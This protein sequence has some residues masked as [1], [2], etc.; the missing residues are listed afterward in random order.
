MKENKKY[1]KNAFERWLQNIKR[2]NRSW[3]VPKIDSVKPRKAQGNMFGW[4]G[5]L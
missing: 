3:Q 1:M 5:I 2:N 4:R